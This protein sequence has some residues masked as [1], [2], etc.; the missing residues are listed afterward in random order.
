MRSPIRS[1]SVDW[2]Q[3]QPAGDRL[4]SWLSVDSRATLSS[5]RPTHRREQM[6]E[7]WSAPEPGPRSVLGRRRRAR[8]RPIRSRTYKVLE[9]KR[10]GFSMG[11]TVEG[12]DERKWSVK[13]P[14]EAPTEVVASRLL[15]GVGYHQP[16]IYYVGQLERRRGAPI[17]NPQLPGALPRDRSRTCTASTP[18]DIWSYYQNPFVG[19]RELNGLLVLQ[20]MLGN[21]DLKDEQNALY[22]LKEPFEGATHWYVAR[23]LGQSFGRTGVLDAPRGD[24]KVFEETPFIKGMVGPYV[25]FDYRGRHGVLVDHMTPA[26]VRWICE[27]A[28]SGSPTRSGTTRSAPAATRRRSPDR[29]IRRFKQKIEEGLALGAMTCRPVARC[30]RCRA[31]LLLLARGAARAAAQQARAPPTAAVRRSRREARRAARRASCDEIRHALIRLPLAALLGAALALRPQAQRHAAAPAGRHPDAD[32]PRRSS[33]RSVMLVVGTNLARAFGVVGA[34]G[35]VRYRAKIEDPKDA[36]VMLSTLAVGPRLR[37]RPVR[38]GGLLGV[39]ILVAALGH[40][41]VRARRAHKLFE[42]NDQDGRRHRRRRKEFDAILRRYHVD[43]ELRSSSD[44]EVCYEVQVPLELRPGSHHQRAPQARS[45]RPRRGR[46]DREEAQDEVKLIIQ[47]GRRRRARRQGHR[48]GARRRI[49]IVIFRFD[50]SEVE[51]ALDAAVARGVA[52][53]ALI[54][55]TNKGGEKTLRKLE[56][57]LLDGGADRGAHRR[58]PG[59]AITAR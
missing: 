51:K 58:R 49:D 50:R 3:L 22:K 21:S 30:A 53:R 26:D 41:V 37:R 27:Q 36:G 55:H 57:R 8:S 7:L 40:R 59:R 33:A 28:R 44:E 48:Q 9:I 20:V 2:R 23:D 10:G 39:F 46:V 18:A 17:P 12:P 29:F 15:W 16:P 52:V 1:R 45:R 6:A 42:L 32:H 56:L 35:L 19:T 25:R 4:L 43:F 13:L 54:A 38:D 34:A 31:L 14:P 5:D 24:S 47:P 11:I